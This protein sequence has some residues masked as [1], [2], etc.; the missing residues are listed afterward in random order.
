MVTITKP[1][2]W[3]N[4]KNK[5]ERE[6]WL[7]GSVGEIPQEVTKMWG[8]VVVPLAARSLTLWLSSG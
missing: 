1:G 8:G 7:V 6:H 4:M 3:G 5:S 2:T